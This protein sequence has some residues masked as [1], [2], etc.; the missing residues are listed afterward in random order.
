MLNPRTH[1]DFMTLSH[2]D[3]EESQDKFP[4]WFG[5]IVGIFHAAVVYT[6]PGSRSVEPQQM[7]F[8]F[9]RWFGRDLEHRGGWNAKR[10]HRIGFVDGHDEAAFGFLDP[11]EVIRGVHLIPAFHYGRTR[12]LLPPSRFARPARDNDEDWQL[13]YVNQ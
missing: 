6:G 8:L 1:A 3:D 9:V 12:D 10:L 7:E 4:Y 11:K 13:F 5:R 2:E